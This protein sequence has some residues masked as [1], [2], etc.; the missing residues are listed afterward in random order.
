MYAIEIDAAGPAS[1]LRWR[2]VADVLPGEGE[3]LVQNRHCGVNF[4]DTYV[5]SGVYRTTYPLRPGLEGAGEVIATGVGVRDVKVGDRVAYASNL[6]GG[7]A[8]QTVVRASELLPLREGIDNETAAALPLQGLTAHMLIASVYPVD[9][10]TSVFI[11]AGAGGV[12]ALAIQLAKHRGARVITTVSSAAK[13]ERARKVGADVVIDYSNLSSHDLSEAI[14]EAT[15]GRGVDVAYDG[16]GAATF[17]ASLASLRPRGLLALFGGASG[18][19][20]AFDLQR[21]NALGSLYVTRPS[22]GPYL[23]ADGERSWRWTELLDAHA[24]GSLEVHVGQIFPIAQAAAAHTAI[25]SGT[26][27]GKILLDVQPSQDR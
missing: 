1:G 14:R 13:A 19:V 11:T 2:E 15:N 4:Y 3:A 23:A 7:Y 21:L 27:Q 6:S 25:E 22:L 18:Q 9:S 5:R 20:P 17:E 26:T 12:G 16:V 24:A 8:E 10:D